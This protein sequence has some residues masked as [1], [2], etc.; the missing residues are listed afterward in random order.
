MWMMVCWIVLHLCPDV[1]DGLLE[2]EDLVLELLDLV[3][4]DLELLLVGGV[5]LLP[6]HL[7][8][9]LHRLTHTAL[10]TYKHHHND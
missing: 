9:L 4:Q 7:L 1:D 10:Y 2:E 5:A 3:E 6:R 8:H